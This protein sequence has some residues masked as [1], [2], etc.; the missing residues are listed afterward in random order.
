MPPGKVPLADVAVP[1][2]DIAVVALGLNYRIDEPR[3]A[4]ATARLARVDAENEQ[5]RRLVARYHGG[6]AQ[7]EGV[8]PT[9]PGALHVFTV[10]VDGDRD[11]VRAMMARRGVQTSLHYPPV[12]RFAI[13]ADG[14][15][16]LPLTDAYGARALTLPLFAGMTEAQQDLVIEALCDALGAQPARRLG[17][18]VAHADPRTPAE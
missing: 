1:E 2:D 6:L 15:P 10:V 7:V 4:V 18:P 14:A 8:V 12:H 9:A 17:D 13:Y 5:R 11:G 3:A 16:D